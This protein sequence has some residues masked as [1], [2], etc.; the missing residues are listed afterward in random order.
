MVVGKGVAKKL[1]ENYYKEYFNFFPPQG[2]AIQV[3]I[4]GEFMSDTALESNDMIVMSKETLREIFGMDE[5][6][7]TDIA[8][9]VANPFKDHMINRLSVP[10]HQVSIGLFIIFYGCFIDKSK[11]FEC[12]I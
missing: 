2:E 11:I 12:L 9:Y 3:F 1:H 7:A 8:I 4:A 10:F 5:M 6:N